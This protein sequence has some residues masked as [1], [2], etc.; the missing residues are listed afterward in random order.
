MLWHKADFL[1]REEL[2]DNTDRLKSI[3]KKRKR[4]KK[5]K[6]KACWAAFKTASDDNMKRAPEEIHQPL[7][8]RRRGWECVCLCSINNLTV[9]GSQPASPVTFYLNLSN[10]SINPPQPPPHTHTHMPQ[11][12]AS[13][14]WLFCPSRF[15]RPSASWHS[16]WPRPALTRLFITLR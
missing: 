4:Q 16:Y 13:S 6:V 8:A 12:S 3:D 1:S 15:L 10:I 7:R 5:Q 2:S 11:H 14:V 9:T